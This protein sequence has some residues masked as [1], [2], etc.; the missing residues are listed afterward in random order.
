MTDL[1]TLDINI[2]FGFEKSGILDFLF[3]FCNDSDFQIILS[4]ENHRECR[5]GKLRRE[6]SRNP[7]VD[8]R[9]SN[10]ILLRKIKKECREDRKKPVISDAD[11]S[12]IAMAIDSG[13]VVLVSDD[14]NLNVRAQQYLD[15]QGSK[16]FQ[17]LTSPNL[18]HFIHVNNKVLC[19]WYDSITK[20]LRY[21]R[22]IEIERIY[23]DFRANWGVS[24]IQSRFLP[25][26]RSIIQT[27]E[28]VCGR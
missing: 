8:I 7:Q 11:Y 16:D 25:Y 21:F 12:A 13:S 2:I 26:E 14:F 15:I 5:N 9:Q 19:P 22:Q 1:I 10:Q 17:V 4:E 18:L 23:E 27:I 3:Q 24:D 20:T 6:L 28:I